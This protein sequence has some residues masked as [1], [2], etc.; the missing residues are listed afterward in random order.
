M[1][2]TV[3]IIGLGIMGGA[4]ARNLTERGWRV[5]GFD[6]ET[7]RR[8]ELAQA[9]IDIASDVTGLSRR[10]E[11]IMTSLPSPAAAKAVAQQIADS[12]ISPRIVVELSTLTLADKIAFEKILKDA[13]HIA[14]YCP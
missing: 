8:T 7:A 6:I 3:G 1:D 5:I 11:I 2:K 14:L 10:S 4:I 9:G 12:A 13:G